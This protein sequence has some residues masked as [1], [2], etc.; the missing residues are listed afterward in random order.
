MHKPLLN[1]ITAV[2]RENNL[3]Y[4]QDNLN[5]I[6][7]INIRWYLIFDKTC[8][9][10]LK[11]P[12]D[13]KFY[14]AEISYNNRNDSSGSIQKNLALSKIQDGWIYC[15]DDDNI[16]HPNFEKC[17]IKSLQ[18]NPE[19]KAFVFSQCNY[20][21]NVIISAEVARKTVQ[22]LDFKNWAIDAGGY[23]VHSDIVREHN[24]KYKE[25]VHESDRHFWKSIVENCTD[26]IAFIDNV[27]TYH[28]G[29]R[30]PRHP[31]GCLA[32][33]PYSQHERTMMLHS[34]KGGRPNY[35]YKNIY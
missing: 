8:M 12:Q 5:K 20:K 31:D 32:Q 25:Y 30:Y 17:F 27:A 22:N 29:L 34:N 18:K 7:E 1:I 19:K 3:Y 6:K 28:N 10:S 24:A 26:K 9:T 15:L 21:H 4:I 14:H 33:V 13:L 35:Q 2:S 16:I 23:V 11:I